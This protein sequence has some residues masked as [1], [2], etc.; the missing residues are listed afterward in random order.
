[1]LGGGELQGDGQ[2]EAFPGLD[3]VV[4]AAGV[5][6]AGV[7]GRG[8]GPGGDQGGFVVGERGDP[9]QPVEFG[10]GHAAEQQDRV[11]GGH[12]AGLGP[13][14]LGGQRVEVVEGVGD[15]ER[16]D[17]AVPAQA[18][19]PV[20]ALDQAGRHPQRPPQLVLD[21]HHI[22]PRGGRARAGAAG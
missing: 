13:I 6:V 19:D 16:H 14:G 7:P 18:G 1:M 12:A 21:L 5:G 3:Q 9:A 4:A 15:L 22:P 11:A 8:R 10:V 2:A 17:A 20:G